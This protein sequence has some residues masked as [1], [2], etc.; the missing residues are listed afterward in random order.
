M[1]YIYK[2]TNL[3]N[4]RVYVGK[5]SKE[6]FDPAYYG[7]GTLLKKSISKNSGVGHLKLEVIEWCSERT[8]DER[9]VF[10]IHKFSQTEDMY[11]IAQGGTGG[12]TLKYKTEEEKAE[13]YRKTTETKKI[14]GTLKDSPET[15][16]IKSVAAKE[17]I[18]NNPQ[19]LP[20]N[21]GRIHT[22]EAL[23]NIK[24]AR[25]KR[26]GKV[27]ITDGEKEMFIDPNTGIPEGFYRGRSDS[28][29]ESLRN[30]IQTE[31]TRKKKSQ[32]MLGRICY[33]DGTRNMWVYGSILPPVGWRK[34]MTKKKKKDIENGNK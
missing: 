27:M 9:E 7:S 34:G 21:K 5:S 28:V 15:K 12:N 31:E 8:L 10:W 32:T 20:N 6:E 1:P 17:R 29:R 13:I 4:G 22:G 11:N 33:T 24:D 2:T 3:K 30:Q 14:N 16:R 26:R 25:A 19:T 18:K 23:Q